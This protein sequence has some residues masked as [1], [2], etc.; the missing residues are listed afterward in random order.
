MAMAVVFVYWVPASFLYNYLGCHV[1]SW[2]FWTE[3][4]KGERRGLPIVI[5]FTA[6]FHGALSEEKGNGWFLKMG[7][8]LEHGRFTTRP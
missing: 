7:N 5:L 1:L 2:A 8:H 4:R 3:E 6:F